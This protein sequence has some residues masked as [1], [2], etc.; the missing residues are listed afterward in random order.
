MNNIIS[1]RLLEEKLHALKQVLDK[2]HLTNTEFIN[3]MVDIFLSRY[4]EKDDVNMCLQPV[5]S[6]NNNTSYQHI[7]HDIDEFL[8]GLKQN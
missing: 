4:K 2:L 8:D 7:I 1:S 3:M 6:K 5:N